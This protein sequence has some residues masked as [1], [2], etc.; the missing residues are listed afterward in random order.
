MT[1]TRAGLVGVA[2]VVAIAVSGCGSAGGQAGEAASAPRVPE[3]TQKSVPNVEPV[4]P[5]DVTPP[6]TK[7]K[8]G[9]QAILPYETANE[10]GLVAVTVTSI[11]KGDQAAFNAKFGKESKGIT[12]YY[13]R[14]TVQ[15]VGDT[16]LQYGVAPRLHARTSTGRSNGVILVGGL[17]DCQD[18]RFSV[19]SPT[20]A[21][22]ES[23]LLRASRDEVVSVEF[24]NGAVNLEYFDNPV[25]WSK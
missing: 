15:N 7:L 13:V 5:D 8:V 22:I 6:G 19:E 11:E 1:R 12:P 16:D 23:C 25:V 21:T 2:A 10:P 24:N 18:T 4:D 20:G 14:L 9:E 3:S 17:D